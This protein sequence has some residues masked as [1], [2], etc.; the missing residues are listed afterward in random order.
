MVD[1]MVDEIVDEID[2]SGPRGPRDSDGGP[3]GGP[4]ATILRAAESAD[5]V[6]VGSRGRGGLKGLFLGSVSRQVVH[7]SPCPVLVVPP[8]VGD[9]E[10]R[11]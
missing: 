5:L 10:R 1:E 8:T 2:A 3:A 6:V 7:H 9:A 11:T 4:A